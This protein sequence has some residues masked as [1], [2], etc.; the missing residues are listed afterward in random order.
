MSSPGV[1]SDSSALIALTPIGQLALLK[2][3]FAAVSIPP[4][5]AREVAPSVAR[6]NWIVECGLAQP[7]DLRLLQSSL[8][9]GERE[10]ISLALELGGQW[11]IL[12]DLPARRLAEAL[13]LSVTGTLGVL[14]YAKRRGLLPAVRPWFDMLLAVNFHVAP[15]LYRQV[16]A[17]VGESDEGPP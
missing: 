4:A 13:G 16:L 17:S 14:V 1:V 3:L 9:A 6:P 15:A 7:I 10:A 8:G 2:E 11:I 12:D 5:V